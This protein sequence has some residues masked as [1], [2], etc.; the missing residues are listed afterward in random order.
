LSPPH[1]KTITTALEE[2]DAVAR[3]KVDLH[4]HH[5]GANAPRFAGISFFEP[6]N[7]RQDLRAP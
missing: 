4:L 5:S 6:V 2:V 1:S 7:S 3:P